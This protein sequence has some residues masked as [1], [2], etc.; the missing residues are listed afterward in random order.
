MAHYSAI[1]KNTILLFVTTEVDIEGTMLSG[2]SQ[3]RKKK[4]P[5]DFTYM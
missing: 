1:K 3:K 5:Y 4:V 2:I